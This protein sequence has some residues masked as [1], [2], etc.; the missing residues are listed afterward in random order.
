PTATVVAAVFRQA[1]A[2]AVEVAS[3][4]RRL[5]PVVSAELPKS[6]F[7]VPVY[8]RSRT[9]VNSVKD[10][11]ET[12]VIAFALVV[13]VIFVFLGRAADTLIPVVALPLS[14]LLT[15]IVMQV[16][17]YSLDNL[18]LMALTLAIGFL[19]DDAIV[20]LEN[21][22][23][24]M[25]AGQGALEATLGSAKEISFTILSM[26]LSLAAVF[27]PL[28][29]MP[30]LIGRIF[31]EFA[32][33][34]IVS[35]FASGIVSLTL[36]PLMCARLLGPRGHGHETFMERI[37]NR[38]FGAVTRFYGNTLWWFLK[39]KSVSA[40]IWVACMVGTVWLFKVVPSS[41]LPVGDSGVMFGVV[42]AQQGTS[43]YQ[44]REHQK[45]LDAIIHDDPNVM[46]SFTMVGNAQFIG[47]NQGIM[48]I[49]LK[50]ASERPP[51]GAAAG[52]LMG[53]VMGSMPGA[54]AFLRPFPVLEIS[55][56]A[57]AQTQGQYSFTVSG[58]NPDETYDASRK[59]LGKLQTFPGFASVFP[60]LED[61]TPNL[62]IELLREQAAAYG[63]TIQ[64][65]EALLRTAYSQNYVYLIKSPTDQYQV[66]VEASDDERSL[67][68]RLDHLYVSSTNGKGLVPLRSVARWQEK[69]GPQSVNHTNQFTSVTYSFNLKPGVPIGDATSFIEQSAKE[70][71]PPTIR[72]E[73][74][75][76]A[77][78]FQET[79]AALKGLM[80]LAV[81]VMYVILGILYESYI[82]PITVLSSLPVALVGGL[83]TLYVFKSEMSLY[84]YI[85]MFMLMGIVK[86]NG[87]MMIDFALQRL[88]AG[89]DSFEAIHEASVERFRPI[90]MTT[91]AALMGAVPI[92]VGLGAD[93]ESRRPLGLVIVGGLLV[94]QFLTLYVTPAIYLYL[95]WFQVN[96]LDR[97]SFFRST[98][99]VD[100]EQAARREL[101]EVRS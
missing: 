36:T 32:V 1:G 14:L 93:G 7:V 75:G 92:A 55:T 22:V 95:E 29:L 52:M 70:I 39:H 57:T 5:M 19:V 53:K 15:F 58:V 79:G 10:V 2:N 31:R 12:L 50:D 35:I 64:S 28:V 69:L 78:L 66:I 30:G 34:I 42:I 60:D 77:K 86:K 74:R 13:I 67:P 49:M 98:R 43:P 40:L 37:T 27:I 23:R 61:N 38:V 44:M 16:L 18:S 48:F 46:M 24:R 9:I 47:A 96:V 59:L 54:M 65:I 68:D 51:I 100:A 88:A 97:T 73:M 3:S 33:T 6:V 99:L 20:F 56:G 89:A 101:E 71:L 94:S 11:R 62:E 25:E 83:A 17:G 82:H 85:G 90:I 76:E 21:T 26:T 72:G 81:F 80:I 87:I 63:V 8:D 45:K 91:L 84:A 4:V 41:F